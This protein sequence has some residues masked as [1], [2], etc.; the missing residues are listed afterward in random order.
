MVSKLS[1]KKRLFLYGLF[2]SL[3]GGFAFYSYLLITTKSNIYYVDF[4]SS[5]AGLKN[6]CAVNY[7]GLN[8]GMVENIYLEEELDVVRVVIKTDYN[9]NM[10]SDYVPT[11]NMQGLAGVCVIELTRDSELSHELLESE[12]II[13]GRMSYIESLQSSLENLN[14]KLN[15]LMEPQASSDGSVVDNMEKIVGNI[16]KISKQLADSDAQGVVNK[17]N[18]CADKLQTA[19]ERAEAQEPRL[20][21][22]IFGS[23]KK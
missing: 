2:C 23:K 19:I 3:C 15:K 17:I 13:K 7:K 6:G 5:V 10:Y 1:L 11:I 8:I 14:K 4:D 21:R 16:E 9:F 20:W 12:S 22:W 18:V